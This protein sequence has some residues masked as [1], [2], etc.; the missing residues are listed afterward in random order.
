MRVG[1]DSDREV[2]NRRIIFNVELPAKVRDLRNR[3]GFT[4]KLS[5]ANYTKTLVEQLLTEFREEKERFHEQEEIYKRER[6]RQEL[7]LSV[8]STESIYSI[9]KAT[10]PNPMTPEYET[11]MAGMIADSLRSE[12]S[13]MT[14]SQLKRWQG[15]YPGH[16]GISGLVDDHEVKEAAL[17]AKLGKL[18]GDLT[19]AELDKLADEHSSE[20]WS[21]K[22]V[23]F[24]SIKLPDLALLDVVDVVGDIKTIT[25]DLKDI[26]R[27]KHGW[28]YDSFNIVS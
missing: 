18:P 3:P 5:D 16:T 27:K 15:L 11:Y 26:F 19:G 9:L 14:R 7:L 10:A 6:I 17:I 12:T 24:N 22:S 13:S 8:A 2:F 4:D 28:P 20:A 1:L 25:Q 23:D 21:A